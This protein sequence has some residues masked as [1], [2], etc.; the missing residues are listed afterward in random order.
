[1]G[2]EL[3]KQTVVIVTFQK[4]PQEFL[5]S[6]AAQLDTYQKVYRTRLPDSELIIWRETLKD[7]SVQEFTAAMTELVT[8][9]PKYE[10][11]D[12]SIQVWRGMPKLPDV[13]NVMLDLRDKAVA[14][15]REREQEKRR[16]EFAVLEKQRKEHPEEFFGEADLAKHIRSM[17]K[18]DTPELMPEAELER[19]K[20]EAIEL[21]KKF[22]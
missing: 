20:Q 11:E 10:L 2:Q 5:A 4:Q 22:S 3:A 21:A 12:G 13:V 14:K 17:F 8:N 16:K 15:A 19:K 7:Y 1:M 9:P 6:I 18:M